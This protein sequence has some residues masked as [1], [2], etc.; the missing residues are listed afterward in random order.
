MSPFFRGSVRPPRRHPRPWSMN[1]RLNPDLVLE[2]ASEKEHLVEPAGVRLPV[3]NSI[4]GKP[5]APAVV[6]D[7]PATNGRHTTDGETQAAVPETSIGTA[8]TGVQAGADT[9][10]VDSAESA[11][12]TYD[13]GDGIPT[14]TA[15]SGQSLS[16]NS[17]RDSGTA[18]IDSP[19]PHDSVNEIS[20]D[21]KPPEVMPD[22]PHVEEHT[23][24]TSSTIE[25]AEAGQYSGSANDT[26]PIESDEEGAIVDATPAGPAVVE[27][28]DVDDVPGG[29]PDASEEALVTAS[30][31][32]TADAV[33]E[34]LMDEAQLEVSDEFKPAT[35]IPEE[36]SEPL[37]SDEQLEV[38]DEFKPQ[39]TDM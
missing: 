38:D 19:D 30:G 33:D 1:P 4:Y 8:T 29:F 12:R 35:T 5:S 18:M 32:P 15:Q 21:Q 10:D 22:V 23:R 2:K 28:L 27:G 13:S 16:R 9:V 6:P 14:D 36:P 26:L 7:L 34:P 3:T 31:N 25:T 39:T 24:V 20:S 17:T 37:I 11:E